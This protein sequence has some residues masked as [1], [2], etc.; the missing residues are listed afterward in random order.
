MFNLLDKNIRQT[1]STITIEDLVKE[2]EKHK[3]IM[4]LC[5][6]FEETRRLLELEGVFY[7]LKHTNIYNVMCTKIFK[8]KFNIKQIVQS[9][10]F[11]K[12][13]IDTTNSIHIMSI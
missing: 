9:W 11:I 2:T 7:L 4:L 10:K 13:I 8:S 1:L 5:F 12:N 6:T 3:K